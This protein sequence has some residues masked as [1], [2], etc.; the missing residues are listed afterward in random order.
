MKPVRLPRAREACDEA[1]ADRVDDE[2]EHDWDCVGLFLQRGGDGPRLCKE[3]IRLRRNE[4]LGERLHFCTGRR[5]AIVDMKVA[6]LRPSKPCQLLLE[7]LYVWI[8]EAN[9]RA[10]PPHTVGLLRNR[11]DAATTQPPP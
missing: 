6:S 4:L 2:G 5:I 9:E 10:D 1:R 7:R 8:V 3:H 11:C